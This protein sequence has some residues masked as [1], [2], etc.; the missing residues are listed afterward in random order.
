M[1][2]TVAE[3]LL[4]HGIAAIS[5]LVIGFLIGAW[6]ANRLENEAL[7]NNA[8]YLRDYGYEKG[9]YFNNRWCSCKVRDGELTEKPWVRPQDRIGY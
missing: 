2:E 1:P 7:K 5:F 3:L 8:E 4:A 9:C 6:F